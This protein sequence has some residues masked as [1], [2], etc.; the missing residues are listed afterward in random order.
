MPAT[1]KDNKVTAVLLPSGWHPCTVGSFKIDRLELKA[2]PE[3]ESEDYGF[4]ITEA[5]GTTIVGRMSALYAV[6]MSP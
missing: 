6:R 2:D 5:G 3:P 1:V 4:A